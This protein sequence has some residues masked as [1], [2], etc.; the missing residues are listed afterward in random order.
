[1]NAL[2]QKFLLIHSKSKKQMLVKNSEVFSKDSMD[3]GKTDL[4]KHHIPTTSNIPIKS[5]PYR[6]PHWKKSEIDKQIQSFVDKG[7]LEE[8]DSLWSSPC[9]LV[10]KKDGS[11]RLVCDYRRLNAVTL[12]NAQPIPRIQDNL[13]SLGGAT[14][15]SCLDLNQ[16]FYQVELD[17][18]SRA[19]SA[20]VTP[21]GRLLQWTA[22]PMGLCGSPGTFEKLV[23][24]VFHGLQWEIL[25]LYIDDIIVFASSYEEAFERL[26]IV[27]DK[28]RNAG[29]KLKAK[30]CVL[31]ATQ[32]DFLGHTI[33]EKGVSKDPKK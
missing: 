13:E 25:L 1:M 20:I 7:L 21:S 33:S 29:L 8:S 10:G 23:E 26:Q 17:K 18:E 11:F 2:C 24:K 14:I 16:G 9:L 22:M 6:A 5:R 19:K 31:F 28:L 15:F 32:V 3:T 12:C 4:V 30:K 27:F